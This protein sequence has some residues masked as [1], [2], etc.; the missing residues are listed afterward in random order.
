MSGS[1]AST[2]AARAAG[3]V[4]AAFTAARERAE[5]D[6]IADLIAHAYS[7]TGRPQSGQPRPVDTTPLEPSRPLR[8][9]HPDG[10]PV[11]QSHKA[12]AYA[13]YETIRNEH[14]AGHTMSGRPWNTLAAELDRLGENH[15]CPWWG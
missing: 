3:Q 2:L 5:W 7:D 4:A 9:F 12:A 11:T 8:G 13:R 10:T 15:V 14:R 6:R 1:S